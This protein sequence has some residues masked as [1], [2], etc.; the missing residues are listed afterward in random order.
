MKN[1]FKRVEDVPQ[2]LVEAILEE[3]AAAREFMG[4]KESDSP[5]EIVTKI[6]KYVDEHFGSEMLEEQ[7]IQLGCLWAEAVIKQYGWSWKYLGEGEEMGV[8]I[9]SPNEYYSCPPLRFVVDIVNGENIGLDGKNDNTILLLFNMLD[10]VEHNIPQR[11][12]TV[13]T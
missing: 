8:Y 9:V 10:G 2:D 4:V 12:Y 3:T 6:R 11:K 7:A 5:K 13:L 1:T